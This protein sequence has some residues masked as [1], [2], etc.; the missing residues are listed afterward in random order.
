[1]KTYYKMSFDEY[2]QGKLMEEEYTLLD[3]D[4]PDAYDAWLGE[5]DVELII[6]YAEAWCVEQKL[7]DL[8]K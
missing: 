4:I 1:M 5:Q 2:L 7:A 6:A 3:D 8:N